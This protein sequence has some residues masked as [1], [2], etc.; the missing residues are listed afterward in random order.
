LVTVLGFDKFEFIRL[1][2]KNRNMVLYCTL[3]ARAQTAD[4]RTALETKMRSDPELS[5]ILRRL[6]EASCGWLGGCVVFPSFSLARLLV[7]IN[8]QGEGSTKEEEE[9][10]QRAAARQGK[11][12]EDVDMADAEEA[13]RPKQILK[14]EEIV[15]EQGGHLMANKKCVLPEGSFRKQ[16]KGYEEVTIPPLK[17]RPFDPNEQLVPINDLPGWCQPAFAVSARVSLC[18]CLCVCIYI[19][20]CVCIYIYICVCVCVYCWSACGGSPS[21]S[22]AQGT[23]A[24]NRV[25]SRLHKTALFTNENLL[26]CAPTGAGKTNVALLTMLH[27][28]GRHRNEDG[29]INKNE[30]KV[31]LDV[32]SCLV[33]MPCLWSLDFLLARFL[34][35]YCC[36]ALMPP[37]A[38]AVQII[39]IA[40]MKSLVQEMVGNFAKRLAPFDLIVNELTGDHQ[41]SKEQIFE[42]QVI[43]CTPEKWDILTR[44]SQGGLTS[45]VSLVIIDEIHLL[46]DDRGPVLESIVARTIRQ[47]RT[48]SWWTRVCV[49]V[50]VF[51]LRMFLNSACLF[52][53]AD[54]NDTRARAAGGPQCHA[55]Q[56]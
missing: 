49:C 8:A 4:E 34:W 51:A 32:Q 56:L 40:P 33:F 14:L 55:A 9:R 30:F 27:E 39:Y 46:H 31:V 19:Y 3:L 47:V 7:L 10:A 42:T 18:V 43:V 29:S 44:K 26:L 1:I 48:V 15:F 13:R 11:L 52:T 35:N 50:C 53:R 22:P 6:R 20:M 21:F 12:D 17:T 54:R 2:R 41:L 45:L 37:L 36:N 24:L 23:E 5:T 25:Q 28:I 16:L 38:H